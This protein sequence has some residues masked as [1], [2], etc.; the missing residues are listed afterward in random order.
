M[1]FFNVVASAT[2]LTDANGLVVPAGAEEAKL[3]RATREGVPVRASTNDLAASFI[4]PHSVSSIEFDSSKSSAMLSPQ[5]SGNGGL[6]LA[7]AQRRE[8]EGTGTVEP[9]VTVTLTR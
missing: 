5:I 1:V 2:D 9:V 3:K 8:L 6:S 7:F 4:C